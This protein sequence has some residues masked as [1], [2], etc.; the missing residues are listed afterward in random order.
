MEGSSWLQMGLRLMRPSFELQ[1][2]ADKADED[3]ATCYAQCNIQPNI[4]FMDQKD[5]RTYACRC[6]ITIF[7]GRRR[8]SGSN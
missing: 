7:V 3:F 6:N 5:A 1:T 8:S 2:D 4:W